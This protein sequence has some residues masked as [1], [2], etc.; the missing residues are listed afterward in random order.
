MFA[1]VTTKYLKNYIYIYIYIQMTV[2][3]GL[4]DNHEKSFFFC[5]MWQRYKREPTFG[6]ISWST[7]GIMS[8]HLPILRSQQSGEHQA[9]VLIRFKCHG[10][11]QGRD[12]LVLPP[13]IRP[14]TDDFHVL[15]VNLTYSLFGRVNAP[16][17]FTTT[18]TKA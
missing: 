16:I 14:N 1:Q 9:R 13:S 15:D 10:I 3:E 2:K 4:Y 6:N 7:G 12:F 11:R 5:S 18:T 17:L 8:Q